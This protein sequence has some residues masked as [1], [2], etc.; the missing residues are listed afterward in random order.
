MIAA[1]V[2]GATCDDPTGGHPEENFLEGVL[3]RKL[4]GLKGHADQLQLLRSLTPRWLS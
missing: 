2:T 1:V 4:T 3:L